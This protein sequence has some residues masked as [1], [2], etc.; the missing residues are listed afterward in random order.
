MKDDANAVAI[1]SAQVVAS[2]AKIR[3]RRC[4]DDRRRRRCARVC[5]VSMNGVVV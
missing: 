4:D 1:A 2:D 3:R 5:V